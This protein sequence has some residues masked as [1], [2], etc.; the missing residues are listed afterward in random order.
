MGHTG[1]QNNYIIELF[2]T[3]L[4]GRPGFSGTV[5]QRR[6]QTVTGGHMI[7][8]PDGSIAVLAAPDCADNR[9][10]TCKDQVSRGTSEMHWITA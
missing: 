9:G 1:C 2:N 3:L 5:A 8:V 6:G 10:I 4:G 7:T